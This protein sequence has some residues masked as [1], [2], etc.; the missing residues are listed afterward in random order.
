MALDVAHSIHLIWMTRSMKDRYQDNLCR[1]WQDAFDNF[2]YL[3]V[4]TDLDDGTINTASTLKLLHIKPA[5]LGNYDF[6]VA[7]NKT[8]INA[9][10]QTPRWRFMTIPTV[11]AKNG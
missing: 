5:D 10:E 4:D 9:Y 1:S 7:G 11:S 2:H 3:P 6:Y 8:F